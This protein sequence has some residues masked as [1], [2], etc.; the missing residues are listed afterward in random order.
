MDWS[1]FKEIPSLFAS[2]TVFE[3][4]RY[5]L[6]S[7]ATAILVTLVMRT[8]WRTRKIQKRKASPSD[9]R[10]E[11]LSSARTALIF[12]IV[13]VLFVYLNRAGITHLYVNETR[14]NFWISLLVVVGMFLAHD[15]YFYWTHRAMHS[16][17]LFKHMHLH[18]HRSVTPTPWAAYSFSVPEAFVHAIF[19]PIFIAFV[20]MYGDELITFAFLQVGRNAFGHCGIELEPRGMP[21]HRFLGAF[22]TTTH[23]DLHHCGGNSHNFGLW[24]TFWDR[25]MKNGTSAISRD[26]RLNIRY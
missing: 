6:V 25:L 15:T 16:R 1:F 21:G 17:F 10:R 14:G 13:G 23:H 7:G 5:I 12:G 2:M 4:M 18:H 11:I 20:P 19:V 8:P 22:T 26:I 3:L 9:L 24:F